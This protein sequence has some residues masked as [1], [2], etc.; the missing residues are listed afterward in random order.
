MFCK[1]EQKR[2][3]A[4][5]EQFCTG[6][7]EQFSSDDEEQLDRIS[8]RSQVRDTEQECSDNE[9]QESIFTEKYNITKWSLLTS[10]QRLY[11]VRRDNI[12]KSWSKGFYTK[13]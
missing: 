9:E 6:E 13:I 3:L 10:D 5:F 4:L 11:K 12:T 1:S 8:Q 7:N 2:V